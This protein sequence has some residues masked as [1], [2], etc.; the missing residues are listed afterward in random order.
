ML[1]R[2]LAI[3]SILFLGG[4]GLSGV[5]PDWMSDDVAGA[6]PPYRFLIANQQQANAQAGG[7]LIQLV[8]ANNLDHAI[9][10]AGPSKAEV[11]A[12]VVQPPRVVQPGLPGKE[13]PAR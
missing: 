7:G 9:V 11:D 3:V 1:V 6:E 12:S 5:L 10:E 4:C 8:V 13:R 2:A